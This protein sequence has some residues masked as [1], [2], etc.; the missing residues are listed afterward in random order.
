MICG[1]GDFST[2]RRRLYNY[3]LDYVGFSLS[4]G[5]PLD[6]KGYMYAQ[7]KRYMMR[8]ATLSTARLRI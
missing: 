1:P 6:N 3:N 2:R 4:E 5:I 7:K 8:K